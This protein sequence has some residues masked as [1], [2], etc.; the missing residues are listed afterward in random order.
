MAGSH[1]LE[2]Y[3]L[4]HLQLTRDYLAVYYRDRDDG[5]IELFS[6]PTDA[7]GVA[8][9]YRIEYQV[10]TGAEVSRKWLFSKVVGL[11]LDA[12]GAFRILDELPN[13]L[14]M[15]R[16]GEDVRPIGSQFGDR[17]APEFRLPAD[18]DE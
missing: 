11:E 12:D 13:Y 3:E 5:L 8:Q 18:E 2:K 1:R 9:L 6:S 4:V 10:G 15:A 7:V 16:V 14:G 17:L